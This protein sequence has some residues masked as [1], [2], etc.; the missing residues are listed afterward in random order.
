M[1]MKS[2]SMVT[3]GCCFIYERWTGISSHEATLDDRSFNAFVLSLP[4][5][6]RLT[7]FL[8]QPLAQVSRGIFKVTVDRFL[9]CLVLFFSQTPPRVS[10]SLRLRG[11]KKLRAMIRNKSPSMAPRW[12]FFV[13]RRLF[14]PLL[15][16]PAHRKY[17]VHGMNACRRGGPYARL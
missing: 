4:E 8:S 1:V 14:G 3:R 6:S 15:C 16:A 13:S 7:Y 10:L 17:A 5:E 11:N 12:R 2:I 9:R